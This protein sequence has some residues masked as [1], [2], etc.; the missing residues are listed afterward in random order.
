MSPPIPVTTR[1]MTDDRLS[2][3]RLAATRKSPAAIQSKPR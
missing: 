3:S 2:T 1:I